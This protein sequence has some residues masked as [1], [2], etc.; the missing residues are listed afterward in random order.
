MNGQHGDTPRKGMRVIDTFGERVGK[1]TSVYEGVIHRY[2]MVETGWFFSVT[3]FI[4]YD[5]IS[6]ITVDG[7]VKLKRS[8]EDAY[9]SALNMR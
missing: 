2:M 8:R 7:R 6:H 5:E 4:L 3:Y 9:R 1:V